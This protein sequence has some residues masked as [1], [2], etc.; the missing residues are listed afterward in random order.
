MNWIFIASLE[1]FRL[2]DFIRDY[3]FVEFLQK[4][5]VQVGDIV[6]LYIT[7]PY[8]RVEYKMVVEKVNISSH[9]AF[10]DTA[11][12]LINKKTTPNE[13]D[14]AVRL[15]F[16]G[17]VKTDELCFSE[18]KKHGF[19]TT[20]QTNRMLNDETAKYIDGFFK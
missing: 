5:K 15:K 19:K 17:R 4:N 13:T 14:K 20:M 6:Y 8:K 10:D 1:Q 16:V 2:H 7:A 3:G 9:D 12:S 18:L 11:Y